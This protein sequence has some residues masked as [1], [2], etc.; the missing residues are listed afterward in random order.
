MLASFAA[1]LREGG[2][3]VASTLEM[4]RAHIVAVNAASEAAPVIDVAPQYV[5]AIPAADQSVLRA[6]Q[7]VVPALKSCISGRCHLHET[8]LAPWATRP[9]A[10]SINGY[11]H[12]AGPATSL[13]GRGRGQ[14]FVTSEHPATQRRDESG[15]MKLLPSGAA[16]RCDGKR[17]AGEA[18]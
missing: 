8:G 16:S 6:I 10:R 12:F 7:D 2:N 15:R 13:R 17:L 1:S 9:A 5:S 4:A 3:G 14:T 11:T 18:P